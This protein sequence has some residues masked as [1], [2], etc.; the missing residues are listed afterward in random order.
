MTK[1]IYPEDLDYEDYKEIFDKCE[2]CGVLVNFDLLDEENVIYS[3]EGCEEYWGFKINTP[4]SVAG[5]VCP[6]CGARN[7]F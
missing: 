6:E 3:R 7:M 4:D 2:H 5:F 1:I